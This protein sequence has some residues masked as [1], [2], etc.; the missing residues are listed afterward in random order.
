MARKKSKEEINLDNVELDE[1]GEPVEEKGGK[2]TSFL[3]GLVVIIIWLVIFALLIKMD[4]GG[5][6][7]MLRPY[8]KNV[9]V[10]NQILPEA[11][12]EEIAEETGYKFNSIAE[13]VE[14]I[15]ELEKELSA[16]QNSGDASAQK[17]AELQAEVD[18]LKVFEENQEYY[19]QLK[20]EFDREVVFTENA[21][22][23]EEYKKWYES[24]DADNAAALYEEVVRQLQHSKEVLNWA[25]TYA[26]MD[27][28]NAAAI[29]EEMTGDTDLVAEILECMT[30][31]QRAAILAEMDTVFAAKLTKIMYP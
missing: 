6:G 11:S 9:P 29:L 20:D 26:K 12:N 2:F 30:S 4:V 3:I 13:A 5:V 10:I 19:E 16:Y 25:E 14:R 18:R 24:I 28:E 22:D 17:I 31:K 27:P 7:T 21:P 15:K 1:N 23:I 8:L